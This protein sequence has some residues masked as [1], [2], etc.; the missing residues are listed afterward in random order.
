[1]NTDR[2]ISVNPRLS[3]SNKAIATRIEITR[4]PLFK[5]LLRNRWPQFILRVLALAGFVFAIVAGLAG[6]PVGSRNFG[7]VFVWI[8]WWALLMLIAVPVFGR[9]WCSICPIP[10][11]GEWLQNGAILGPRGKGIGLGRRWPNKF[12]NIWLQNVTFALVALFSSIVLTQPSVT[13]LVLAL[14][15]A[16][17]IGASLI[18]ERRA[19]CRYLCPVG[20]FIG[21]YAQLAP[22]E[23]RVKDTAVCAAHTTKTCYTGNADGYGCPWQVFPGGLVKNTYCGACME[24]LRTCPHDN[25]AV[26]LRAFGADL[27]QPTSRKLD[28]AFKAFIMLGS[29]IVYSAVMLGPWGNLKSAAYAIGSGEWLIYAAGFLALLFGVLPGAFLIAVHL[30]RRLSGSK[31]KA[32]KAFASF[33]YALIPLGLAA[34]IAFSLSFVFANL[35]YVWPALSDPLGRGWNL[36]GAAQISWTPYL[37]QIVP[38]LQTVVLLGGLAWASVAVHRI[39]SEQLPGRTATKQAAPVMG[40]CLMVTIGLLGLLIG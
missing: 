12:R 15:L 32:K 6:T 1:M 31:V 23:L 22:I 5:T 29:A 3:A 39:A 34:W 25:I 21:L 11:P 13:A 9:G 33:A 2:F 27:W 20:G 17:A 10:L 26:N 40:F 28:E 4:V 30:G 16:L 38:F 7:I 18:F 8:A 37:M 35:S 14:F 36:L 24:C 19:F